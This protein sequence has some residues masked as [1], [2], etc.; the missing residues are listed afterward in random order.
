MPA[1]EGQSKETL[2]G[3]MSRKAMRSRPAAGAFRAA[4]LADISKPVTHY[5]YARSVTDTLDALADHLETHMD[6]DTLLAL[7]H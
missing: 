1:Q 2:R 5:D 7:A 6:I 4:F 3:I